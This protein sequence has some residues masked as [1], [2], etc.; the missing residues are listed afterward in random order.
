MYIQKIEIKNFR[1]LNE[2]ELSL[3]KRTTVIVGRNNSGKTS[4]TELFRRLLSDSSPKFQLEDFS[5]A[6]HEQFWKA[7]QL[8]NNDSEDNQIKETLPAIEARLTLSYSDESESFGPLSDFIVDLDPDCHEALVIIRYEL[9]KGKIHALLGDIQL[10]ENKSHGQHKTV[11]FKAIKDRVPKFFKAT[12]QAVD[13]N[14]PTNQKL[15]EISKLRALLQSGFITAQ[16]GLD[17]TTHKDKGVLCGILEDL[18]KTAMSEAADPKD[19]DIAKGLEGAVQG[20]QEN[21]DENFNNQ[22][23]NLLPALS[24][25]GYPGLNDPGLRTETIFNVQSLLENHTKVRY[26]GANG[27]NLPEAYNGLGSRNLIFILLQLL[28]F[29]KS[30]NAK[31]AAPRVH[32]VFVEEPEA[33]L[34]P[35]MQEV[36]VRKLEEISDIFAKKYNGGFPW[37]VQFIVTTHSSHV[38]NEAPFSAMRY[39]LAVPHHSMDNA[40]QTKIKDLSKGLSNTSDDDR[41]F[42]HQY[43]TLTRCDLLFADKA[44]LIEGTTERILLPKIIQKVDEKQT[45]KQKLLSSQYLS[46]MEVGGAYAHIFFDLLDFL[47]LHTLVITDLDTV[48]PNGEGKLIACQVSEGTSTSNSCLKKWFHPLPDIIKLIQ[49]TNDEKIHGIR[50]LSICQML[51]VEKLKLGKKLKS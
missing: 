28:E 11:F 19:R 42:L 43:M 48:R 14:D 9:E 50:R 8:K 5:L 40:F 49:K 12:V 4:L 34:H 36:F 31:H 41:N 38:A 24:L 10:E 1:L 45:N 32:L 22:L 15:L 46:V 47:E 21:I 6:V 16:R 35:Q 51:L 29:F 44:V 20:I 17:D 39:F 27:I 33:H 2:V 3:E 37:P 30:F 23:E 18:F 7:F 13:P 25:F 26:E